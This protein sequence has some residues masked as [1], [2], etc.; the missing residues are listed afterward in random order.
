MHSETCK[1]RSLLLV[2]IGV[3]NSARCTLKRVKSPLPLLQVNVFYNS[4]TSLD[5]FSS[6]NKTPQPQKIKV[7]STISRSQ[8]PLQQLPQLVMPP[9]A[10]STFT[11]FLRLSREMRNNIWAMAAAESRDIHF[12][13]LPL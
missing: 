4:I 11:F 5:T 1:F 9:T 8:L 13:V 3:I 6:Q 7:S 2:K 12:A 10:P